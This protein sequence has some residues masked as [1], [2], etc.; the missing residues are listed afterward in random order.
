MIRYFIFSKQIENALLQSYNLTTYNKGKFRPILATAQFFFDTYKSIQK[1][2]C[3]R[4]VASQNLWLLP[5]FTHFPCFLTLRNNQ[6]PIRGNTP[7]KLSYYT[8]YQHV[9]VPLPPPSL[10]LLLPTLPTPPPPFRPDYTRAI[11]PP[12]TP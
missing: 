7:S 5:A 2:F 3:H 8:T 10:L 6:K 1:Y 9:P 4:I 12:A 11:F